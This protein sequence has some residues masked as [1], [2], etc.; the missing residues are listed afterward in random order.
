MDDDFEDEYPGASALATEC[1]ANL[2]R[3][4]DLLMSLHNRLTVDDYGLS[5]SGR[6]VLAIIEG[7]GQ[8]LE[9]TVIAERLLITTGSMTS[10]L[11]NLEKR[12]LIR[13]LPH[14]EDRRK[15]LVDI[16]PGAQTIVDTLLP[17]LHAREHDIMNAALN[18]HEQQQLLGLVAKVQQAALASESA[19]PRQATATRLTRKKR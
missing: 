12:E 19:P 4:G 9:P 1:Y 5:P 11:D 18:A 17:S 10:L 16:T 6:Q 7:A 13:R 14:P 8:P 2:A 3:A 15:L